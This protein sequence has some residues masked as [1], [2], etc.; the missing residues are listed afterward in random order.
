MVWSRL[1]S[2]NCSS[3]RIGWSAPSIFGTATVT[4]YEVVCR[5]A[6]EQNEEVGRLQLDGAAREAVFEGL[7]AETASYVLQVL[8]HLS[9]VSAPVGSAELEARTARAP[10]AVY[11]QVRSA[12]LE[13]Q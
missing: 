8:V 12:R 7:E 1:P 10:S 2:S 3:V 4:G 11:M 6:G 9:D 13:Q 5:R